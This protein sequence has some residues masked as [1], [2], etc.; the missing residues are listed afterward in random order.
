LKKSSNFVNLA[1]QLGKVLAGLS[2][3]PLTKLEVAL[4]G[5]AAD[6]S[7]RPVSV[8]AL[9]GV[10]SGQFSTPVNR[11]NA[12]NIAKRQGLALVESVSQ[13][14]QDYVSLIKLTGY[15]ADKTTTISGVLL[16]G[17]QPRLVSINELDIE[18]IPEGT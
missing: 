15:S 13:E 5:R 6:V 16:G 1:T 18:V 11:V 7:T 9:V 4:F 8:A 3:S 17:R 12:E 10:L 14:S 2:S